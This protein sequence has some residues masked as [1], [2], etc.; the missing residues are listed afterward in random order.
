M[1]T[2]VGSDD[3]EASVVDEMLLEKLREQL[4]GWKPWA[5]ELLDFYLDGNKKSSARVLGEKY[6]ISAMA[7]S[8]R[9]RLLDEF[10]KNFFAEQV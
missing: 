4:S 8:K 2:L 1:D 3:L 10:I 5:V 7:M 6:G 9:K